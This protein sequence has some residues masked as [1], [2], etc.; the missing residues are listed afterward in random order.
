MNVNKFDKNNK[1][2]TIAM[3]SERPLKENDPL[4]N[5]KGFIAS[6]TNQTLFSLT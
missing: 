5:G 6:I 3:Y 2:Y 4:N 1:P